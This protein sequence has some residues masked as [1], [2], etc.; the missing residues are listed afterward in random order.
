MRRYLT[1]FLVSMSAVFFS[2]CQT[3]KPGSPEAIAIQ[4]EEEQEAAVDTVAQVV[5]DKPEWCDAPPTSEF[6]IHACDTGLSASMSIAMKRAELRAKAK[7]LDK[8]GSELSQRATDFQKSTGTGDNEEVLEAFSLII[9]NVSSER[10]LSGY[11]VIEA[12][13]QAVNDKYRHY[14]LLEYP[15]GEANKAFANEIRQ[16]EILATQEAA[17]AALAELEAEIDKKRS[18]D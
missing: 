1:V 8:V 15:I 14:V 16:N 2:A 5:N 6:A 13:T 12:E 11:R 17:D 9:K 4:I 10:V 7:L 3:A 18:V